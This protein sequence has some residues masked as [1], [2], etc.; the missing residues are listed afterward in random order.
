MAEPEQNSGTL[1]MEGTWPSET[2]KKKCNTLD[3]AATTR[4]LFEPSSV[5]E[6][7]TLSAIIFFYTLISS[8]SLSIT[9]FTLFRTENKENFHP[10][11]RSDMF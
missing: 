5:T 10:M 11:I 7:L 9:T 6:I 4:L 1:K 2:R 3:G 8:V